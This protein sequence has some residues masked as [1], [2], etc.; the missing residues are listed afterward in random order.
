MEGQWIY[1]TYTNQEGK[2][3][4][5]ST[6]VAQGSFHFSGRISHPT[7]ASFY[8][9]LSSRGMDDANFFPGLS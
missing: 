4:S 1:L 2:T 3:I 8:G 9:K 7:I 6:R 5:D